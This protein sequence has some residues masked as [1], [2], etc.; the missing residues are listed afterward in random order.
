MCNSCGQTHQAN[1]LQN[2]FQKFINTFGETIDHYQR[3]KYAGIVANNPTEMQEITA[4]N[5]LAICNTCENQTTSEI[6]NVANDLLL[7]AEVT[8]KLNPH[9]KK[10][11]GL[12]GCSCVLLAY[13]QLITSKP[14]KVEKF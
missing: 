5:R 8:E 12:C 7:S 13:D 10:Q 1:L 3:I 2:V 14:C 9:L 4:L 6:V 11:C